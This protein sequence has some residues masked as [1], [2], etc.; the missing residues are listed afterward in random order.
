M[1]NKLLKA[2]PEFNL[3]VLMT[4]FRNVKIGNIDTFLEA[5]NKDK[6][7][8]V[9]IQFFDAEH[10]ATWQHLYFAV[11][12]AL[13]SLKNRRNFSKSMAMEALLY[14]SAQ[15]QISRATEIVGIKPTTKNIAILVIGE[16]PECIKRVLSK[17]SERVSV[18][19]DESVMELSKEK[20]VVLKKIFKISELEL[21]TA[22]KGNDVSQ[23]L[24]DLVIERMSLLSTEK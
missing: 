23:A 13:T 17:V 9:E 6:P 10:V 15:H 16:K 21:Q 18:Q 11:I 7:K 2:L 8:G 20:Q 22:T 1:R 24:V 12:N 5:V 14:A 19:P 4:G 3:H